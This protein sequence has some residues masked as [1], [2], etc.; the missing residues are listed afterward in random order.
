VLKS[1]TGIIYVTPLIDSVSIGDK[2]R[3]YRNAT[4][5]YYFIKT[6]SVVPLKFLRTGFILCQV[7]FNYP[8]FA[9]SAGT[10]ITLNT[11]NNKGI[12]IT[13]PS[14]KKIILGLTYFGFIGRNSA[15]FSYKQYLGKAS[16]AFDFKKRTIV[17]SCAKNPVDHPNGGRTRGKQRI[18]TP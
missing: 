3:L 2:I 5:F 17:R 1:L 9:K 13:L 8:I 12:I 15:P 14:G 18:K 10:Y 11:F 7:G 4:R 6:G 16:T